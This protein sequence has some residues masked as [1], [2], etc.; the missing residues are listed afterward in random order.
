[1]SALVFQNYSIHKILVSELEEFGMLLLSSIIRDIQLYCA[2]RSAD[3]HNNEVTVRKS[4]PYSLTVL[5]GIIRIMKVE[6]ILHA[7]K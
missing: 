5:E 2:H 1:M 3:K 4:C 7:L 6:N